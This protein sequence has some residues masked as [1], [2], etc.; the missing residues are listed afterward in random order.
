VIVAQFDVY[1][2]PSSSAARGV[3]YVVNV[4][5]DLIDGLSTRLCVPLATFDFAGS[6]PLKLSPNVVVKG[7]R[8]HALAHFAAPLPAARL[9]RPVANVAAEASAL[10]AAIDVVLSGV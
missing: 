9:R 4:Q 8:L 7:R 2:N 3:P 10:V 5:S 6:I 1:P